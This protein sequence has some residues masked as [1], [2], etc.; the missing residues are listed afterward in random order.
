MTF[1]YFIPEE[2][3]KKTIDFFLRQTGYSRRLIIDLKET[4]DGILRNSEPAFTN[5]KLNTGDKLTIHLPVEEPSEHISPVPLPFPVIYEDDHIIAVNKPADMPIHPSVNNHENT[6]ANAA[7]F[8]FKNQGI[9]FVFRCVNRLDRDTTGLVLL[10][11]HQLS[12]CILSEAVK[13]REIHREYIS[14]CQGAITEPGTVNLPIGRLPGSA[15]MRC[16]DMEQGEH[17]VTHYRPIATENNLTLLR[18]HLETG[19]THQ[20]RI[21]MGAIGHPLPGDYLYN[22]DY[23]WIKR[24]PLHSASLTFHHPISGIKMHLEVPV[25]EDMRKLFSKSLQ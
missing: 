17:A 11:K 1:E 15:I 4:D 24:Q 9:P 19:R 3:N 16:V 8:Y 10:A 18:I 7:A 5:V 22:P 21:H 2:Y 13:A 20:I 14:I 25:P 12:G 23:T 6:L